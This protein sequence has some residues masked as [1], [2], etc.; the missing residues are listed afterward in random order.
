MFS[1]EKL[2]PEQS[3]D[4]VERAVCPASAIDP[5]ARGGSKARGQL[6]GIDGA[7][8]RVV[9]LIKG[10]TLRRGVTFSRVVTFIRTVTLSGGVTLS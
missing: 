8:S 7:Q 3:H 4:T 10:V 5:S 2:L 6:P 9:T 1:V